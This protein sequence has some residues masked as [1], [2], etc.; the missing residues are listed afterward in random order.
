M[1]KPENRNHKRVQ[2]FLVPLGSHEICPVWVFDEQKNTDALPG[3]VINLSEGGMQILTS[4]EQE[5]ARSRYQLSFLRDET[6]NAPQLGDCDIQLLWSEREAG[7]HT[8]SG[9][10]FVGAIP[11]DLKAVLEHADAE[12]LFLR[13]AISPLQIE[14]HTEEKLSA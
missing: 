13:C 7:L 12:K 1:N 5:L 2:F 3:L 10:S 11:E 14:S 4:L 9:F 6:S 8:R